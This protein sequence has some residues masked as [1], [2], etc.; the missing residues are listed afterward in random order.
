MRT[1][2]AV[3]WEGHSAWSI[4]DIDLDRPGPGEVQV[5]LEAAGLCH[6]DEH[7]VTGGYQ[8]LR[9]PIVGGHEGAGVV[10][11][12][13]AGVSDLA[14]GD[15]VLLCVPVP[16]CGTCVACLRGLTYLCEEGRHTAQGMQVSDGTARHHARGADL[17]VFVFLGTF[18]ERTVVHRLSCLKIEPSLPAADVCTIS[19][20]GVTGWG[21]V[22]NTAAAR[23]GE[24]VAVV[25]VG[26]I[27]ANALMAARF[28]GAKEV[29]AVDPVPFKQDIAG[30]FGADYAVATLEEARELIGAHTQGRMAD[31]VVLS[32]GTGDGA[33]MGPAMNVLGKRGRA[34]VVNVHHDDDTATTLRLK[35]LQSME[36]QVLGCLSGS[37]HGVAGATFLLALAR[38]GLYHPEKLV[39]RTYR[40]DQLAQG[41]ADQEAARNVRGVVLF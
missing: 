14:P 39:T 29:I 16:P 31:V 3:V 18:A 11:E 19:C 7:L 37:W 35:D 17:S 22:Q 20:A 4:E 10:E 33:L 34:V 15:H 8:G 21:A 12:V 6:S 25:G 13:G 23:P 30:S 36:K 1:R 5:R 26:G 32:I 27:G 28:I 9:R 41:Y 40:L 24:T 38:R 2:A